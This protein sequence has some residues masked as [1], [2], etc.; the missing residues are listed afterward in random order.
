MVKLNRGPAVS[1]PSSGLGIVRFFDADTSG[2][3][4]SPEFVI[5]IAIALIAV[6]LI[7]K[8]LFG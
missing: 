6:V 7:A 8:A 4:L 5:G 1:G 2:P 3:K